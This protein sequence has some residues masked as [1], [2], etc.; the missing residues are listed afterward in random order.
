MTVPLLMVLTSRLFSTLISQTPRIWDNTQ[1]NS[2]MLNMLRQ[3]QKDIDIASDFPESKDNFTSSDKLLLIEQPDALIGYE[4]DNKQILRRVL[5]SDKTV[6]NVPKIW[7][8]PDVKIKWK[9]LRKNGKGYCLELQNYTENKMSN[10][11]EDQM[12][13]SH[14][15]FIG[16]L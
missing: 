14:L 2:T 8:I 15:F 3:M 1:Q 5:G 12:P 13:N 7:S 11:L 9:V 16:A 6:T 4:L 10:G